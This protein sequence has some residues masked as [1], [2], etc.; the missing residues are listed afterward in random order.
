MNSFLTTQHHR[1]LSLTRSRDI[2]E[3][4][5]TEIARISRQGSLLTKMRVGLTKHRADVRFS[6][7]AVWKDK[8]AQTQL[9][10]SAREHIKQVKLKELDLGASR[11]HE[12]LDAA[13]ALSK[14]EAYK[15]IEQQ[16]K[17][18]SKSAYLDEQRE[19]DNVEAL[20]ASG[21]ISAERR[22]DLINIIKTGTNEVVHGAHETKGERF[23]NVDRRFSSSIR[24]A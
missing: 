21:Q 15:D 12:A 18:V 23:A 6:N 2:I 22:K 14:D 20:F 3:S 8:E 10:D 4:S 5:A 7:D 1:P 9:T 16:T 24:R 19:I 17:E 11:Q 13:L